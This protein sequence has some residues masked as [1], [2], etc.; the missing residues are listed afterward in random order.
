MNALLKKVCGECVTCVCVR[1]LVGGDQPTHRKARE[2]ALR[3][4]NIIVMMFAVDD[5][6]SF[7]NISDRVGLRP[8]SLQNVGL[9]CD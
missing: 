1:A 5:P 7:R 6:V 9:A 4:C 3:E 8:P 2:L